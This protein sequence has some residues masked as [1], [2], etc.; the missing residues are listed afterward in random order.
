MK[1]ADYKIF[2]QKPSKRYAQ[3]L[4]TMN[5]KPIVSSRGS[6]SEV[7]TLLQEAIA[8]KQTKL[9]ILIFDETINAMKHKLS[10][11]L[12][13]F[14]KVLLFSLNNPFTLKN[15]DFYSLE[16]YMIKKRR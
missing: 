15:L 3:I 16:T 11:L 7:E 10:G 9:A 1:T 4:A 12:T 14:S 8:N 13:E 5:C 2:N 6:N